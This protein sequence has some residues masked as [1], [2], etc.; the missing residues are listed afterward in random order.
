ME[1]IKIGIITCSRFD[2]CPG[3]KCYRAFQKREGAFAI[4]QNCEAEIAINSSCGGCPG[5][6]IESVA[7]EL[8]KN[9]VT[10][11]HLAT[12]MFVGFPSCPNLKYFEKRLKETNHLNVIF[13]THPIPQKYFNIHHDLNSWEGEFWQEVIQPALCDEQTRISYD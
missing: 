6:N 12:G 7:Q 8:I 13:G 11:V 4:Y 9:N 1:K 5:Y 2:S 10:H 3:G